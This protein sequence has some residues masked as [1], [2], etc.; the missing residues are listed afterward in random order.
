VFSGKGAAGGRRWSERR[1]DRA[2]RDSQKTAT[3]STKNR[4]KN[5]G[6]IGW[7]VGNTSWVLAQYSS[8]NK[9]IA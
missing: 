8:F 7:M 5:L 3:A 6:M 1:D 9:L 2:E 4:S